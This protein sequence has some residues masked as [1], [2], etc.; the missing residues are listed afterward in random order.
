MLLNSAQ[1]RGFFE[2]DGGIQIRVD[3]RIGGL[4][5]RPQAKFAQKTQN[6]QILEWIRSSLDPNLVMSEYDITDSSWLIFPFNSN[7]GEKFIQI[8]LENKPVNPGTLKDFKI[9]FLIY[10]YQTQ[11]F[12][13]FSAES[14]LLLQ[15]KP[16]VDRERIE[17]LTLLWLRFERPATRE[18]R[19]AYLI[20][21]YHDYVNATPDEIS[22]AERL[23]NELMIPISEEV[24]QL[25]SDLENNNIQISQ[26][27]V[28]Y[29]HVADGSLSFNFHKRRLAGGKQNI[30]IE[31]RWTIGDDLLAAPLLKCIA[32]QYNFSDYQRINNQNSGYI[33]ARGW[34]K[35]K[36]V[37]IPFFKGKEPY[38]PDVVANKVKNFIEV[39]ELHF[40][41]NTFKNAQLYRAYVRKAYFCNPESGKHTEATFERDYKQLMESVISDRQMYDSKASS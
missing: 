9:A 20:G 1:I 3:K 23:G 14:A 13:P 10:Q 2:G 41:E 26:D 16:D 24:D 35:A 17:F 8:Y 5:F 12:I 37:I 25:V 22:E 32:E 36:E 15:N 21:H 28:A 30:K 33:R 4:S 19:T 40:N 29:Y 27:Y 18:T 7:A 11:R 31:P 6:A 38:L 39:C 34:A